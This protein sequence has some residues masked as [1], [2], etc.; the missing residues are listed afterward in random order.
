MLLNVSAVERQGLTGEACLDIV[1]Q[2]LAAGPSW[3]KHHRG[4]FETA[5]E[6]S[7][8]RSERSSTT[9]RVD[10][11]VGCDGHWA[12]SMVF[13]SENTE[14]AYYGAIVDHVEHTLRGTGTDPDPDSPSARLLDDQTRATS[15]GP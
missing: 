4:S 3:K 2:R 1:L 11:L 15:N 10:R 7:Y 5:Y 6:L 9:V 13:F 8:A 12:W 14:S